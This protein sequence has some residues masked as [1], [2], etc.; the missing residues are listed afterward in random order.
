LEID[1]KFASFIVP[2]SV[3]IVSCTSVEPLQE[4]GWHNDEVA[5]KNARSALLQ[6]E[7]YLHG[8]SK[9][10][11]PAV[12]SP[13]H[14]REVE[15]I[16]SYTEKDIHKVILSNDYRVVFSFVDDKEDEPQLLVEVSLDKGRCM[17]FAV[18]EVFVD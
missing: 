12:S 9:S 10:C 5:A 13:N 16:G 4:S 8:K 17:E 7:G 1:V 14:A 18:D 11:K 2:L 3:A 15:R 6:I